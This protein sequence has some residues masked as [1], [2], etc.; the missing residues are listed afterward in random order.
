VLRRLAHGK[1][2]VTTRR[3]RVKLVGFPARPNGTELHSVKESWPVARLL[4]A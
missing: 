1:V 2:Q 3:E 4:V